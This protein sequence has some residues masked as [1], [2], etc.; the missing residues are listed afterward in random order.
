MSKID[1]ILFDKDGTLFDFSATW[2]FWAAGVIADF[3]GGQHRVFPA[4]A[5]HHLAQ[6]LGLL[7]SAID[8][9]GLGHARRIRGIH[10]RVVAERRIV[11][12]VRHD[13]MTRAGIGPAG[14][15]APPQNAPV[16]KR[17]T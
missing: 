6:V 4:G 3:A 13:P 15:D 11:E 9:L 8:L 7:H 12:G 14:R 2:D 16:T 1:A 17:D 5:G 10:R